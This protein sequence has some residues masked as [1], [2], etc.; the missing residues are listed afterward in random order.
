[1]IGFAFVFCSRSDHASAEAIL[2]WGIT[3]L[4]GLKKGESAGFVDKTRAILLALLAHVQYA[5]GRE[6]EA[7]AYLRRAADLARDFDAAPDYSAESFRYASFTSS[8]TM[9]DTLGATAAESVGNMLGYAGDAS[10]CALW[11]E[12]TGHE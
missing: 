9:Y 8:S 5:S 3:L 6:D 2:E 1:M 12:L 10:L 4:T 7:H 11:K